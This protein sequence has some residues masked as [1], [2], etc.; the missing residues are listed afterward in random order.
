VALGEPEGT[1]RDQLLWTSA[2][3]VLTDDSGGGTDGFVP[4]RIVA[5]VAASGTS[6]DLL[7]KRDR[8][9]L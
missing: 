5:D 4:T 8:R 2:A 3:A 7:R 1:R 9:E 6:P